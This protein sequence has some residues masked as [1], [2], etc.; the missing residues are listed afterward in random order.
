MNTKV[1]K[2][3]GLVTQILKNEKLAAEKISR[4]FPKLIPA[5]HL[6]CRQFFQRL[7][8]VINRVDTVLLIDADAGF[9]P[10]LDI[11]V[12]SLLVICVG[13]DIQMKYAGDTKISE[14]EQYLKHDQ[15]HLHPTGCG[16]SRAT[17]AFSASRTGLLKLK[18]VSNMFSLA[19]IAP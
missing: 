13:N 9:V 10:A 3:K 2:C 6:G 16:R 17:F 12:E 11:D 18:R 5:I 14:V 1:D 19:R 7:N 4:A 8:S 15:L